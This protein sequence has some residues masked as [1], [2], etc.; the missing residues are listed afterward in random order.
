MKTISSLFNPFTWRIL[1]DTEQEAQLSLKKAD[2]TPTSEAQ[3]PTSNYEEKAICQRWHSFV[4][5]MLTERP[6]R[7]LQLTIV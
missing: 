5:A 2:R 3:R 7:K 6:Y 4:L 1:K